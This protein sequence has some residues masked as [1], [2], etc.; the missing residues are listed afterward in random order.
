MIMA[1]TIFNLI[2]SAVFMINGAIKGIKKEW[3]EGC[4]WLLLATLMLLSVILNE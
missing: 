3:N 4:Y 1:I 2:L